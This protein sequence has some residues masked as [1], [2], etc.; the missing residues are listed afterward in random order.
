MLDEIK[1]N[2][3]NVDWWISAHSGIYEN[4]VKF[5]HVLEYEVY[6]MYKK[7][8]RQHEKISELTREELIKQLPIRNAIHKR[9]LET[10]DE[11]DILVSGK[12]RESL[13]SVQVFVLLRNYNGSYD[14]L[15]I[16]RSANVSSKA[17][18]LQF[19]P[20]GGFEAINDSNDFDS[21]WDN[22]SLCKVVFR[23]LLE[24]CFGIDENDKSLTS[25]NISSDSIYQN[26]HIKKLVA[27]L[28]GDKKNRQAYM[29]LLGLSMS[30][31]GLRHEFCFILRVDD[32]DFSKELFS[33]YESSSAIHLVR[34]DNLEKASFWYRNRSPNNYIP[35]DF[36]I[37]HCTSAG[38]FELAQ[39][40]SLYKDAL[41]IT[42]RINKSKEQSVN[43]E[44]LKNE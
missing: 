8:L 22:Y 37:L 36:E 4:N 18:Y 33:N 7:M 42:K 32:I 44:V 24:E 34:I 43:E 21:Q 41:K 17:H 39:K 31:M 5:S 19:I 38:L 26:K 12:Y 40:S 14:V 10:G 6:K 30:L 1:L 27:M 11:S 28:T 16:R 25:I 13:L 9:F 3:K 2:T 35:N 23:E 15:R 20:S 29:E